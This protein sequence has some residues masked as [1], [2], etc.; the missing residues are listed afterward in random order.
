MID[1][2]NPDTSTSKLKTVWTGLARGTGIFNSANINELVQ[3][4][5]NQSAYLQH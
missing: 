4:L 2:K 3:A 1:L 5:F